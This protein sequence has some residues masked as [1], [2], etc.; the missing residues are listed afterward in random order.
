MRMG[1]ALGPTTVGRLAEMHVNLAICIFLVGNVLDVM[2][3]Y[4]C[5]PNLP[6]WFNETLTERGCGYGKISSGL[7]HV[8]KEYSVV[9]FVR[10]RPDDRF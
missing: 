10:Y 7:F 8:C 4:T 3:K 1:P 2:P 9:R 5:L 6:C